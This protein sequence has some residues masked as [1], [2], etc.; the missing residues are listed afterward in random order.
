MNYEKLTPE[1]FT[2]K[3][4]GDGPTARMTEAELKAAMFWL[5]DR[6]CW[7][8]PKWASP[9]ELLELAAERKLAGPHLGIV[10]DPW[11][12]LDHE[13]GGLN[14]TDYVS[15]VLT[16]VTR[17]VR[18]VNAH[19][20]LVVHPMKLQKDRDG[21]RPI[22]TPYDISGSAHWY[23]KADN[24]VTIHRRQT[25][26]T[27]EVEVHVQKVRFRHVGHVGMATLLYDK[28]TGS[29]FDAPQVSIPG[30]R[31]RAPPTEW[32][33]DIERDGMKAA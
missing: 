1:K 21:N 14:E 15:T 26:D 31:Y 3:P 20:W 4:F 25:D 10:L 22:P 28:V 32:E 5:F 8:A 23:N 11:N 19:V 7:L 16:K 12:T 9:V 17:L 29:Y 2:G 24:I 18:E 30:D 6:Y 27:Q 33:A 13:R